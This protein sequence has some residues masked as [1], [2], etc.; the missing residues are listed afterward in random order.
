MLKLR[1]LGHKKL[2]SGD[3]SDTRTSCTTMVQDDYWWEKLNGKTRLSKDVDIASSH[4]PHVCYVSQNVCLNG[5]NA[6]GAGLLHACAVMHD[7]I[8][9]VHHATF[10]R[11]G[12]T[13]QSLSCH[14][15]KPPSSVPTFTHSFQSPPISVYRYH[16]RFPFE[17]T[18]Q[19]N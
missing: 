12:P 16:L 19:G 9:Q 15:Q 7:L 8:L 2:F 17:A 4:S 1:H 5:V 13:E 3:C 6:R 10:S 11:M 14:E 18:P